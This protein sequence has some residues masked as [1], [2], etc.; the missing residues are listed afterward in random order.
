MTQKASLSMSNTNTQFDQQYRFIFAQ[1]DI[2]G[3][4]VQ[5]SQAYQAVL[6]NND[7]PDNLQNILGHF[8]C[9]ANLLA[10]TVKFEG[11]LSLQA[12]GAG[13]VTMIMAE[14]TDN[15]QVR[16][17][18][19]VQEGSDQN[20]LATT[21]DLRELLGPKA[22]LAI[23]IDPTHGE[24]YQGI[25]PIDAPSLAPCLEHYF[26]QSEQL[27]TKIWLAAD[28][29]RA[30]G[31]L[32]QALPQQ[33]V[34]DPEQYQEQWSTAAQLAGTVKNDELL[35]LS[36]ETLVF[37]LFNEF[38]VRLLDSKP[39]KF[40]CHCSRERS[41]NA[42]ISLG[43]EEVN[44]LLLEQKQIAIDCHF[45]HAHYAFTAEDLPTLFPSSGLP[46]H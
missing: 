11:I 31:L 29:Q 15:N 28:E 3:E 35:S 45:C 20:N 46:L 24:R 14:S 38:E 21:T 44:K 9:A 36:A 1:N 22:V 4:L 17:I 16:A 7:L 42:L 33:L 37:R 43:E 6:A 2:R 26:A 41:A 30:A 32:L 19:R 10:A 40:T 13:P 27:D 18:V 12:K 25:V 23:T 34:S 5:Q 8:L 39:V